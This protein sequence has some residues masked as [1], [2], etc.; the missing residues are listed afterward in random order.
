MLG[1]S[2]RAGITGLWQVSGRND[3]GYAE[4]VALDR[5]YAKALTPRF[6]FVLLKAVLF[7][8]KSY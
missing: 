4:R 1:R 7:A 3:I 2:I 8:A 6:C 5:K